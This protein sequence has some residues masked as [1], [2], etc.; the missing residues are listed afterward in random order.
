MTG[1]GKTRPSIECDQA[2]GSSCSRLMTTLPRPPRPRPTAKQRSVE[3]KQS[4]GARPR[5]AGA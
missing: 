5:A 4:R 3:W 1:K 2:H